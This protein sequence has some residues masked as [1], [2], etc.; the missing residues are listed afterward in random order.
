MT[1]LT[2]EDLPLDI[3]YEILGQLH[4][5]DILHVRRA[6]RRLYQASYERHVWVNCYSRSNLLL[7][8]GPLSSQ[9]AQQLEA[10]L[11]RAAKIHRSWT[12]DIPTTPS[13]RTFPRQLPTYD[14]VANVIS[15]RYLQVLEGSLGISWYDLEG[16]D[17]STPI[18]TYP[19]NTVIPMAGYL[20]YSVNANGE[21]PNTVWVSL[22][23]DQPNRI[24]ILKVHFSPANNTVALHAQVAGVNVVGVRMSHDWLLPIREFISSD[25]PMDLFHIPSRTTIHIPL[26]ERIRNLSDLNSMNY[27]I[28]PRCLFM[29]FSLRTETL[30]DMYSLPCISDPLSSGICKRLFPSHSGVYPHAVSSLQTVETSADYQSYT[31]PD[32]GHA[33][34]LALVYVSRSPTSWTSKI[35][36]HLFDLNVESTGTL[37]FLTK[38]VKTLDVG[39]A[40]TKLAS[41]SRAGTCLAVTHS[42]PGPTII[43]HY[44]QH[45]DDECTMAVQTLSLPEGLQ[46]R[47]MLSFDGIQ[48][49]LCLISGWTN[50]EILDYA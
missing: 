47:D 48:G 9:S 50:I 32:H 4:V 8:E 23:A 28:T 46:S 25:D 11:V 30:V 41:T 49:R 6:C 35:G 37:S 33:S 29:L 15:G 40:T 26:H 38:S 44:I 5:I 2:V 17:L 18:L 31:T 12:S 7:P 21:G 13:R 24:V 42:L 16:T 20:N 22:V 14:F 1:L 3:V 43:A 39:I 27:V 45:H 34:F 19:C 36:L 10:L